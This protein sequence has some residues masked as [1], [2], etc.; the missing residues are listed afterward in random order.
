MIVSAPGAED[1]CFEPEIIGHDP[2]VATVHGQACAGIDQGDAAA[3]W[4][5][6]VLGRSCRLLNSHDNCPR[7]MSTNASGE[8]PPLGFV[9]AAHVLAITTGSLK[10][11]NRR[12]KKQSKP[13]LSMASFRPSFVVEGAEGDEDTWR[14][15]RINGVTFFGT[16]LC[17]R[18]AVTTVNQ[19]TGRRTEGG[20]PLRTLKTYRPC[21]KAPTFG[22]NLM[23]MGDGG[24]VREGS[25]VEVLD[26]WEP[27]TAPVA[28]QS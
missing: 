22:M 1:L 8:T 16:H 3:A 28:L 24:I 12:L 7:R 26:R 9:D 20:E 27:G 19:K 25:T 15:V 2:F 13:T 21:G 18:C 6:R 17:Q 10:G 11:L 4:F 23:V 14:R 5:S